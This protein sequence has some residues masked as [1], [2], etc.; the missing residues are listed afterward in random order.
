MIR[1]I[2]K[3]FAFLLLFSLTMFCRAEET[4]S[5][6]SSYK[7]G[8]GDVISISVLGEDELARDKIRLTDAGT[9]SF[10]V[11]GEVRVLGLTLGE[12]EKTITEGLKKGYLLNP[13]VS[14]QLDEY[15]PFFVN[16]MVE[17]PGGYP[18]QP[19]LTVRKA[20]SIAGGLKERASLSGIFVIHASDTSQ[21]PVKVDLNA[22]VMPG[23]TVIIEQSFF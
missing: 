22:P 18:Y 16:G 13:Q 6:L 14:A 8:V 7:L 19:G 10:P 4:A 11:L 17:K 9:I 1:H 23:D 3:L 5:S 12:V 15:R 2:A 20:A 21:K